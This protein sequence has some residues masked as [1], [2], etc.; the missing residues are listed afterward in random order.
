MFIPSESICLDLNKGFPDL[1]QKAARARVLI[2]SPTMLMLAVQTVW[3][4]LKDAEFREQTVLIKRE[5]TALLDDLRRLDER[6]RK[7]QDHFRQ[8]S[9]D[10][11]EVLVS[12]GKIVKRGNRI[13]NLDF[14]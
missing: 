4:V 8:A 12:S 14:E 1:V 13:E 7:L 6:T 10:V 5:V 11:G 3:A 9:G 2:V